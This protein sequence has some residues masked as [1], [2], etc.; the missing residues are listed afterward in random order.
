MDSNVLRET[1]STSIGFASRFAAEDYSNLG[2]A[3]IFG[4]LGD[5]PAAAA[6]RPASARQIVCRQYYGQAGPARVASGRGPRSP[7]RHDWQSPTRP[8]GPGA[9][10]L[11]PGPQECRSS[12]SSDTPGA[13]TVNGRLE[14]ASESR[15]DGECWKHTHLNSS[16][17]S[18][19]PPGCF[20]PRRRTR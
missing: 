18:I 3:K 2:C 20:A 5:C 1:I 17:G 12:S 15:S 6:R 11:G 19:Q 7:L 8:P 9:P 16:A 14:P 13:D 10:A 4:R